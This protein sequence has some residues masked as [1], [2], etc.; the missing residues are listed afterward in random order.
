MMKN[1]SCQVEPAF[2]GAIPTCFAPYGD[3]KTDGLEKKT[4]WPRGKA[5]DEFRKYTSEWAYV[6]IILCVFLNNISS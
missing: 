4:F 2:A 1:D 5:K 3:N 6:I